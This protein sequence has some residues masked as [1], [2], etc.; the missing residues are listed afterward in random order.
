MQAGARREGRRLRRR[1]EAGARRHLRAGGVAAAGAGPRARPRTEVDG[2]SAARTTGP[3]RREHHQQEIRCTAGA[4]QE[5]RARRGLDGGFHLPPPWTV[6]LSP[7]GGS[8]SSGPLDLDRTARIRPGRAS[9]L[10]RSTSWAER[11]PSFAS[12]TSLRPVAGPTAA[13][14]SSPLRRNSSVCDADIERLPRQNKE[15]L[16][17]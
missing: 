4:R 8:G 16:D 14:S 11:R 5:R 12:P 6:F 7:S 17:R 2:A 10:A 1:R 3:R 13:R 9:T 15:T